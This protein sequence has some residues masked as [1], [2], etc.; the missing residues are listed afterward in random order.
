MKLIGLMSLLTLSISMNTAFGAES[1]SNCVIK[2]QDPVIQS[3]YRSK[4]FEVD[5]EKG[6]FEAEFEVT[7]EAVEKRKEK[8]SSTEVHKTTTK[9]EFFE[10]LDGKRAVYHEDEDVV[11]SGRVES[12]FVVPCE[13]TKVAKQRLLEN[14]LKALEGIQCNENA[15]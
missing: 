13:D 3:F 15:E 2:A 5:D 10:Q 1:K 14:S 9:L 6:D 8:F 7:C 4:G 11:K 12:A